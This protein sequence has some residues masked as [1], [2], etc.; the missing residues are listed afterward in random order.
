LQTR[1]SVL[2]IAGFLL[3]TVLTISPD[4]VDRFKS[5]S[6]GAS[7]EIAFKDPSLQQIVDMLSATAEQLCRFSWG[8][9]I[10]KLCIQLCHSVYGLIWKRSS[11]V[12]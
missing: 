7:Y 12:S 9:I 6:P 8:K 11:I 3:I 5:D 1:L 2:V 10:L 4:S